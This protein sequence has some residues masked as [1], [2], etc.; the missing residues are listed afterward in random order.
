MKT[1]DLVFIISNRAGL[2][3]GTLVE[4]GLSAPAARQCVE[5]WDT[6]QAGA[7]PVPVREWLRR[8]KRYYG[9]QTILPPEGLQGQTSG[10]PRSATPASNRSW[11]MPSPV[12]QATC[13]LSTCTP[14]PSSYSKPVYQGTMSFR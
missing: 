9:Q 10:E 5:L 8:I 14:W 1:G 2:E 12:L 4:H 7:A 13:P 11:L 6:E 3:A